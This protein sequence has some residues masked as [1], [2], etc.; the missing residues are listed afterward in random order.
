MTPHQQFETDVIPTSAGDLAITFFGHASLRF[1][2]GGKEIYVDPFG[3]AAD[4][5]GLPKADLLLI[6]HEHFDHCDGQA[7]A[8]IRTERTQVVM[9][10]GCAAKLG[11]GIVMKNGESRTVEGIPIEAVPA[12]NIIHKRENGRPFHMPGEGNGYVAAFG[13]TR[14]YIAGDTENI[15]EMRNLKD[16]DIAFLPMNVPYTMTAEMAAEA[17]RAIRPRIL[18]PYHFDQARLPRLADLLRDEKDIE[19]RI[20]NMA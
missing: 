16:I 20:R 15:P 12:Y 10:A 18:Y 13:S 7:I 1:S 9:T 6:T 17:A 14:V 19:I 11:D 8:A 5:S 3:E 4:Y 2:F